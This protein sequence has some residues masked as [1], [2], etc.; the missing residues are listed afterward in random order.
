GQQNRQETPTVGQPR[1]LETNKEARDHRRRRGEEIVRQNEPHP[2]SEGRKP[3]HR[4]DFAA[5]L[6]RPNHQYRP[7]P[8]RATSRRYDPAARHQSIA[9]FRS[10]MVNG[11]A[12]LAGA[13]ACEIIPYASEW[14]APSRGRVS[15]SQRRPEQFGAIAAQE[16]SPGQLPCVR[17]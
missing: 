12:G 16:A 10:Y 9:A 15:C 8:A 4:P 2:W 6:R 7:L 5:Q 11:N 17:M 1:L 13:C 3:D 14:L